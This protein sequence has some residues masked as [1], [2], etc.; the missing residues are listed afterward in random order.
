M[1]PPTSVPHYERAFFDAAREVGGLFLGD[2]DIARA[3]P[4]SVPSA[5]PAPVAAAI[6]QIAAGRRHGTVIAIAFQE[7]VNPRKGF[8]LILAQYG[9][10]RAITC[11][12]QFPG[13]P[14]ERNRCI[15]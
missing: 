14:G 13:G 8:E 15:S 7:R 1:F 11:F 3:W 6:E 10:C 2:G 9:I 4:T 12:E 5:S